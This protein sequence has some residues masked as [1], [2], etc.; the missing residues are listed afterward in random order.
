MRLFSNELLT[1]CI[2]AHLR[3]GNINTTGPS[4]WYGHFSEGIPTA[5]RGLAIG[6]PTI[7]RLKIIV[8]SGCSV[9]EIFPAGHF[10]EMYVSIMFGK[11]SHYS[12]S[13]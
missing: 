4:S 11:A 9:K 7:R 3:V 12:I 5:I 10:S 8:K 1:R 6:P 2:A 13:K